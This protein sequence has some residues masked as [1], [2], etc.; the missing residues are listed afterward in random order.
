MR[1]MQL[2]SALAAAIG[3]RPTVQA[4][5]E[6]AGGAATAVPPRLALARELLASLG[7]AS[8]GDAS[9]RGR[10]TALSGRGAVRAPTVGAAAPTVGAEHPTR[11][12]SLQR[13]PRETDIE[14]DASLR[15]Q[16]C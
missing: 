15:R 16:P 9:D 1:R 4:A 12:A 6:P 2:A 8:S 5:Q 11:G 7:A 10:P 13:G 14:S 3:L